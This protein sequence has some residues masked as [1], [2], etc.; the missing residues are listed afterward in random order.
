MQL[1]TDGV[2]ILTGGGGGI[3]ASIAGVFRSAG[4]RLTLVDIAEEQVRERATALE[5]LGVVADLTSFDEARRV[6]EETQT[7][8]GRVD[9]LIH[10]AGG[11][12][13]APAHEAGMDL[14]DRLFDLN[15]RTLVCSVR[16]VLPVLRDRDDGF[17]AGI[18]SSAVW[19]D[20][21]AGMALYAAAKGAVALYLRS[22][23][24]ELHKT[25]IR[26]AIVYPMSPVDTD[27]NRRSMPDADPRGWV[28]PLEIGQAL[29]FA[30]T[31]GRRGKLLELPIAT[32]G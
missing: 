12:A 32:S 1:S 27:T 28:D 21:T 31:R 3:A 11:F 13:M 19:R 26:V 7:A 17:I 30:A 14:Y 23:G 16:A 24:K 8:Y 10:A 2:Y 22:I 18:S 4:A 9:G 5:A 20:G 6:V 29:L 25:G 15:V